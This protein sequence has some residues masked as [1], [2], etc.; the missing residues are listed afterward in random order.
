LGANDFSN[1]NTYVLLDEGKEVSLIPSDLLTGADKPV[2]EFRDRRIAVFAEESLVRIRVRNK[3]GTLLAEKIEGK[4]LL[5][6]PVSKQ[7]WELNASRIFSAL[8]SARAKEIVDAAKPALRARLAKPDVE[9]ELI[10]KDGL[11]LRVALSEVGKEEFY[12]ASSASSSVFKI[13]SA[14]MGT[15]QFKFEDLVTEPQKPKQEEGKAPSAPPPALK[16]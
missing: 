10:D 7:G 9:I 2:L 8:E 1:S 3:S 11:A 16:K 14:T 4:W 12:S 6:E 13:E 15:L 5:R